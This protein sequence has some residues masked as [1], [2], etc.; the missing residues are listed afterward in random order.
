[1]ISRLNLAH[2]LSIYR[3][4]STDARFWITLG[5]IATLFTI[6]LHTYD[7]PIFA[8]IHLLLGTLFTS[9]VWCF[10]VDFLFVFSKLSPL[11][12]HGTKNVRRL[13]AS[14]FVFALLC[15]GLCIEPLRGTLFQMFELCCPSQ[16]P[17]FSTLTAAL[18]LTLLSA[19]I[20]GLFQGS[21][22]A[23]L[24]QFLEAALLLSYYACGAGLLEVVLSHTLIRSARG[25]RFRFDLG[26]STLP[27]TRRFSQ[28][29]YR[30]LPATFRPP[31]KVLGD[32]K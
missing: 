1:M 27:F 18:I 26:L 13:T 15:S 8:G 21:W 2:R 14:G 28:L 31:V 5:G 19:V 25:I 17:S 4:A 16:G 10:V 23:T 29:A 12:E 6:L 24:D 7:P 30:V 9:L 20:V 3:D 32:R 11:R 22:L